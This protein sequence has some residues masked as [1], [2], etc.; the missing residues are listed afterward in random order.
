MQESLL[1]DLKSD[2]SISAILRNGW[3]LFEITPFSNEEETQKVIADI[4]KVKPVDVKGGKIEHLNDCCGNHSIPSQIVRKSIKYLTPQT[5]LIALYMDGTSFLMN[6]P[7]AIVVEPEIS[8]M[9]F[10]EHPHLNMGSFDTKTRSF[11]PD[12][13][14]L[15]GKEHDWGESEKDRLYEA[16]SQTAIWLYRH[17]IWVETRRYKTRGEWIGP[18]A[19]PLPGYC[20]PQHINPH[21]TCWCGNKKSYKD[22][23]RYN[24]LI[25]WA[26][27]ISL[28]SNIQLE[29]AKQKIMSYFINGYELW[30]RQIKIPT[31]KVN[32]N[33]KTLLNYAKHP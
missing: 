11:F 13:L 26:K 16:I 29:V 21:G 23:H 31:E 32:S 1:S 7:V 24:D 2:L 12:S 28:K 27:E 5:F 9:T 17:Q 3:F 25:D 30:R 6:R 18:G 15:G 19:D 33:L 22:C 10:P 4:M 8:Y 14:C 20:Y